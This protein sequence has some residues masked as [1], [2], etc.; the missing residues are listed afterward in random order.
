VLLDDQEQNL[1]SGAYVA[2]WFF[3]GWF[4]AVSRVLP[5]QYTLGVPLSFYVGRLGVSALPGQVAVQI[6]W[7]IALAL[8]T[9]LMWRRA[10]ERVV[11]QGG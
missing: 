4:G 3:P 11:S 5:F 8:A 7:L 6:A 2:I 1:L 10:G 9:R